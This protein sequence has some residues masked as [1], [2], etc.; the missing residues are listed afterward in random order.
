MP[1][2]SVVMPAYNAEQYIAEAI[3][4]VLNQTFTDYEFIVIDDGSTDSTSIIVASY[5]DARIKYVSNK[6]N[7]G[8][9]SILF[10]E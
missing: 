4:S 10:F 2:I 8:I 6:N 7:Q 5:Q 9:I 1:K 3:E